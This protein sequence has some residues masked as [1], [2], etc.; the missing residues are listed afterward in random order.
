MGH[1]T[2]DKRPDQRVCRRRVRASLSEPNS[3]S[4]CA[5][6]ERIRCRYR[7]SAFNAQNMLPKAFKRVGGEGFESDT[8]IGSRRPLTS[9]TNFF[10]NIKISAK[11][12][13]YARLA[14][15][16]VD[17]GT[18]VNVPQSRFN[19]EPPARK[20]R[21][22]AAARASNISPTGFD[23]RGASTCL[24]QLRAGKSPSLRRRRRLVLSVGER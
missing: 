5:T 13:L 22:P 3:S 17:V 7:P 18:G 14:R 24:M 6:A 2:G 19:L 1:H 16:C 21:K 20:W 11:G 12:I 9:R 23:G 10:I 15:R 4:A 8:P